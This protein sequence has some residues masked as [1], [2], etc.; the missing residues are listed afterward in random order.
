MVSI[1]GAT[2]LV[3]GGQRGLGKAFVSELLARGAAKVYVTA[4]KP[5]PSEDPRVVPV[6]LE[7]TD[8]DSVAELAKLTP[9]VTIVINNAGIA[10]SGPLIGA[11]LTAV[12]EVFETNVFGAL[13]I[14]QTYAP[15]LAANGGGALVNIHSALSWL[16]G[17]GAYGA[18]KAAFWSLTNSLRVELEPNGTQ[19]LGV[20]LGYADTDMIKHVTAPKSDPRDIATEVVNGLATGAHEVLADDVSRSVKS[21]LSGPVENLRFDR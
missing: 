9:D 16:G 7:V 13:R 14:A 10:G 8:G 17:A 19:V 12:R 1:E 2:V 20:H 6:E 4:R 3:T 21:M 15:V 11:D 18:S 5:V